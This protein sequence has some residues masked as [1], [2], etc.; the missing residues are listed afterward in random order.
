MMKVKRKIIDFFN[1]FVIKINSDWKAAFCSSSFDSISRHTNFI[2]LYRTI[3]LVVTLIDLIYSITQTKPVFEW[4]IYYTHL[5]LLVT[6]CAIGFQFLITSRIKFYHGEHIVPQSYFQSMHI[7]L[8]L[9]ALGSGLAVC[10]IYWT[11]IYNPHSSVNFLKIVF[12]HGL[13]WFLLFIDV[14]FFTRLPIYMIDFIPLMI[15]SFI[16]G[17]FTI[18]IYFFQLKFSRDRVGF[19]YRSFNFNVDPL[20]MTLLLICFIVCAPVLII[21]LLW[22]FF[23]L[24]R[25]IDVQIPK[26]TNHSDLNID[27]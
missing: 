19:V 24:R 3:L 8:L 21:F 6:F 10:I 2:L 14:F 26:E 9:I 17:L 27:L 1:K 23:R 20:R 4:M 16:Y 22:N 7:I 25:S 15:S 12:D 18:Y 11:F 5:T 13:L